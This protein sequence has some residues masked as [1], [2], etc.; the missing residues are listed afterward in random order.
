MSVLIYHLTIVN[1][2][3]EQIVLA[4]LVSQHLAHTFLDRLYHY[5]LS[6]IQSLLPEFVKEIIYKSAQESA[7]AKLDHCLFYITAHPNN[8]HNT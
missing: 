7:L 5:D 8:L 6:I 4:V 2:A 3:Q 1:T